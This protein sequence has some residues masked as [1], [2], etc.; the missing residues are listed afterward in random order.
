M[1]RRE[2]IRDTVSTMAVFR[3]AS[4]LVSHAEAA[5]APNWY[6]EVTRKIHF[7][8]HTPGD[9]ENVGRD[10]DPQAF[11]QAV[12]ETG[13]EAVSYFSCCTYG[14]SYY[15][16]RVGLAHPHLKRDVFGDGVKALKREGLRVIAYYAIDAIPAPLG[17][18]HIEWC[19]CGPDGVPR[20]EEHSRY[21]ACPIGPYPEQMLIPQLREI[22]SSYPV[23]GFFLDGVYEFFERPCYCERCQ[24]AFGRPIP[25]EPDDPTW[26]AF[27]HFQVQ[28]IWE[29]F[30]RAA[31]EVARVR[32]GCV[33]GVNWMAA[34]SYSVP[35]PPSIGYLTGDPGVDNLTFETSYQLAA[36]SWRDK[37]ADLMNQRMLHSWSDFTCRTP[38]NIETE[39]ATALAAGGKLFVGDL[40][41]PVKVRPDPEIMRLFRTCFEFSAPR[42][43]LARGA[44]A[45]SDIAILSS[46][47]TLRRRGV[48]WTTDQNPLKGAYLALVEDGLT[49]DIL[50]DADLENHLGKYRAL[51]IPEQAFIG[52]KAGEAIRRFVDGGG[53]LV[54]TG[55][56]PQAVDP[57]EPSSAADKGIFEEITGLAAEGEHAFDVAYLELRGTGA[58]DFWRD[59]D[60]FRPAIP[61]WGRPARVRALKGDMLAPLTAPGVTY[62]EGARPPGEKLD[63]PAL[64]AHRYGKGNVLFCALGI[65]AEVWKRGNPGAKYV[66]QKMVRRVALNPTIERIGP[67]SVQVYHSK[68]GNRTIIQLIA[69]QPDRRVDRPQIVESP[70]SVAGVQIKL[71][72]ARL[73]SIVR[74]EPGGMPVKYRRD[75]QWL[76]V[77]VPAFSIHTAVA[78]DWS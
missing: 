3:L 59:K 28:R 56:L 49:T 77:E 60:N 19:H 63:S 34:T 47:E 22:A 70:A 2:F 43:T 32:P 67:P 36:W 24:R 27:R 11:A 73:P 5:A 46:P 20:L 31:E 12:K 62:Q 8:M 41:Q 25:H 4:S 35:P 78:F 58:E 75:G 52:R 61:V 66:L 40:L 7:D 69:Y 54:V 71:L 39:F 17:E 74:I 68:N 48:E 57:E 55:W 13:A 18:R 29:V 10:F 42:E 72:E 15:P 21:M 37:P 65:A 30:G 23:D 44:Q 76:L 16:T 26:R 6:R 51:V 33:M 38:E 1:D 53:G 50:F 45:V 14:W 64:T 9:V